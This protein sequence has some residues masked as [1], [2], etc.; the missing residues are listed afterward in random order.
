[1]SA[2]THKARRVS[3]KSLM[4]KAP[5]MFVVHMREVDTLESIAC[6][7]R[8]EIISCQPHGGVDSGGGLGSPW[9]H[10]EWK[11]HKVV[12]HAGELLADF[13]ETF[14]PEDAENIRKS[15]DGLGGNCEV[16]S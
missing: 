12:I 15:V 4:K 8:G 11:G 5:K 2:G 1:M 16:M 10:L 3:G 9:I 7:L 6:G 13:V 14:D